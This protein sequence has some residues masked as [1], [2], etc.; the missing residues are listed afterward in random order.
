MLT[1][2]IASSDIGWP[3]RWLERVGEAEPVLSEHYE[4][5]ALY[6]RAAAWYQRAV[7]ASLG[8]NDL[9]AAIVRAE[10]G[11][12]C[13]KAIRGEARA[14]G[15]SA[16]PAGPTMAGNL[17]EARQLGQEA[18]RLLPA[19]SSGTK[20]PPRLRWPAGGS[21]TAEHWLPLPMPSTTPRPPTHCRRSSLPVHTPPFGRLLPGPIRTSGR[22]SISSKPRYEGSTTCRPVS[23]RVAEVRATA[24]VRR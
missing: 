7:E 13:A 8:A 23:P 19:P 22:S 11:V 18:M 9:D 24:A 12:A 3:P 1:D 6:D 16:A 14:G 17:A 2:Q 15:T 4:K 5:G 21:A 10:R 20:L